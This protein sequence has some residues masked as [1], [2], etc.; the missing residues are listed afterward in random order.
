MDNPEIYVACLAAYNGGQ[1]HGRWIPA[2]QGTDGIYQDI[3]DMLAESPIEN[4]EEW[5][6][7]DYSGFGNIALYEFESI[8][9]VANIADFIIEHGE[10]GAALLSDYSIDDALTLLND[11]YHGSYESE[12]DFSQY[13]FEEC[14]SNS[15]PKNLMFYIDHEAFSR[16]LFINDY[17]SIEAQR[18]THVFSNY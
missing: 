3:H 6:L 18:K 10:L 11:S 8:E 14:Y 13:I 12:I 15:I 2:T 5:A 9:R 7:H 17:F 1:L 16:D 4:A